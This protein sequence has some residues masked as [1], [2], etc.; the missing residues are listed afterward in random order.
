MG[1][2]GYMWQQ[3]TLTKPVS[4]TGVA[5]HS[6]LPVNLTIRPAGP[7]HGIVFRRVDLEGTPRIAARVENVVDSFL[8]THLGVDGVRVGVVEHLLAALAGLGVD[9]ALIDL[10]RDEVPIMD[11]SSAPFVMLIKSAG[12]TGQGVPRQ[13]VRIKKPIEAV[14]GDRRMTIHP[15]DWTEISFTIEFDHPLLENQ[16]L[17]MPLEAV[18]FDEDICRARTF[19]FAKDVVM[20]QKMGKIKGGNMDNAVVIDDFK[21]LN[22]SGLRFDDEFVRHKILDVVG[23]MALLGRPIIGHIEA[24]KSGHALNHLLVKTLKASPA[25]WETVTL[26]RD[27]VPH[28]EGLSVPCFVTAPG[29]AAA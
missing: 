15:S 19:G 17:S 4:C 28:M 13:V 2:S 20:L 5:L 29:A 12:I 10:D 27:E 8:A 14:D 16:Q 26:A 6:G 22:P 9:N 23:D 25:S 21:V 24:H 1:I 7:D 3:R 18:R 11:G